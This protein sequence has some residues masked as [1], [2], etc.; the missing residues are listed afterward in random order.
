MKTRAATKEA[1]ELMH[2]GL[3]AFVEIE[4]N[5][6]EID[7]DYLNH[8]IDSMQDKAKA[9]EE[10]LKKDPFFGTWKKRYG[11][12][13]KIGSPEQ[14]SKILFEEMGYTPPAF[15]KKS[16]EEFEDDSFWKPETTEASLSKLKNPFVDKWLQMRRYRHVRSTFLMNIK[17]EVVAGR[18]HPNF[19]LHIARTY[20][21]SANHPNSQNFPNRNP[22]LAAVVRPCFISRF[23][24]KGRVIE[25][26]F[27]VLEVCIAAVYNGDPVLMEYVSDTKKD[28]HRDAAMM[29]FHLNQKEGAEKN[30]RHV[31]K[32]QFVFPEFY[33]SFWA[34]CAAAMWD[35]IEERKLK[36]GDV[37]MYEHLRKK[38]IRELGSCEWGSKP[39]KGTFAY[40]VKE[41][42][43]WFWN[44]KFKVYT[45][46]K[47]EYWDAYQKAGYIKTKTGF[48][49]DGVLKRNKIINY[50]IQGSA[51]HCLLWS[52][53]QMQ[54]W[55]TKYK[56]RSVII[57]QIHDSMLM[58]VHEDEEQDI[59]DRGFNITTKLLPRH[60]SWINVPL[61]VE[62]EAAPAGGNWHQKKKWER[63][64]NDVWGPVPA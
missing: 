1:Y 10:E 14:I 53:I 31:A 25:F 11:L 13:T 52:L 24:K 27:K 41:V 18:I 17:R 5:G 26:D 21:S 15:T 46:W 38:G 47:N 57:G 45:K 4:R 20:R 2:E 6:M 28:M 7:V 34:S 48:L 23:G 29:V 60:W 59:L 37:P 8:Q 62:I 30:V 35:S 32:N 9:I 19:N 49:V 61:N 16:M 64:K 43:D 12:N 54:K 22:E 42:E 63:N 55:L 33:G 51:F 56:M 58:D 44:E 50:P 39:E 3:T 40:H 36:A